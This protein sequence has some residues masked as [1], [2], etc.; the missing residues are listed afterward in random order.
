M[1]GSGGGGVLKLGLHRQEEERVHKQSGM[2]GMLLGCCQRASGAQSC[3]AAL[4][5][6]FLSLLFQ[7]FRAASE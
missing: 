4:S 7:K 1:K 6:S 5:E 2:Q 3:A